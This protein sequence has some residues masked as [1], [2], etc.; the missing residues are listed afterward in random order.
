MKPK[1]ALNIISIVSLI[2]VIFSGY[3][4]FSEINSGTCSVGGCTQI[5]GLPT[6]I[7]GLVM[8]L[9]I[10]GLSFVGRD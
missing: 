8:Y 2:G 9:I 6:C 5:L 10:L 4:S 3:L 7:Y 1:L